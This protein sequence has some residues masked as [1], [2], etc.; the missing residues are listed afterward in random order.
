MVTGGELRQGPDIKLSEALDAD[1]RSLFIAGAKTSED[2]TV[3]DFRAG[4]KR[5][6]PV[7]NALSYFR[8]NFAN[9]PAPRGFEEEWQ[10]DVKTLLAAGV[11]NLKV[12]A[13]IAA[14]ENAGPLAALSLLI[15]L[16]I[17]L[18]VD[19]NRR[20]NTTFV[21]MLH[22]S[23]VLAVA[24]ISVWIRLWTLPLVAYA[25]DESIR[26]K[27][28]QAKQKSAPTGKPKPVNADSASGG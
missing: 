1:G 19:W 26:P 13:I 5:F 3:A 18:Y 6:I 11:P 8:E 14:V 12:G 28:E 17:T 21:R 24:V 4:E 16:C 9:L 27:P 25:S 15:W 23:Y 7:A 20:L 10:A 22:S 2:W